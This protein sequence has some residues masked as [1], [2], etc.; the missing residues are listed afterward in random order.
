MKKY[1]GLLLFCIS[2]AAIFSLANSDALA[3]KDSDTPDIVVSR[4]TLSFKLKDADIKSVLA[5]F[6]K[7]LGKNIVAG[8]G[9]SGK[10]TLAF[11]NVKPQEGFE[12]V[13]RSKGYDWYQEGDT[14]VVSNQ[15]T[16][17]TYLLQYANAA[18]VKNALELLMAKGD[19]VS[20]NESYNALIVKTS[21]DNVQRIEKSIRNMDVPPV[22]VMVEARIL[23]FKDTDAG[24]LGVEAN[25]KYQKN[26]ND[27]IA[28]KGFAGK[29][30]DANAAG[31]FAQIITGNIE[32][33]LSSV[34]SKGGYNVIASPR[35][36][37][38]NHKAASILIGSKLGYKTSIISQTSTVQQVNFLEIGTKLTFT[39][40]VS[41]DGFIRM[42]ISPK[43]SD[44]YVQDD[45][46]SENTTETLNEVLVRNG[47]T[48]IIGGLS[49][50]V[51]NQ[52]DMGVPI[53]MHIPFIGAF[54]RK[55]TINNEKRDLLIT[56]TPTIMTPE[57]LQKMQSE[58][59]DFSKK[60]NSWKS[61]LIH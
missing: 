5:I 18:E 12:S 43:I 33:Y 40:H 59:V 58:V 11:T 6:A 32:T 34:L 24:N 37:T 38:I 2:A 31:F 28:T 20:V 30:T 9:V 10:V 39:P 25:V 42:T 49:R 53:L 44:G 13:L 22:Q 29:A 35:I 57:N 19:Q 51:D 48:V 4:G 27:L 16:V 60:Q 54:F 45:L 26:P 36:T 14:I 47:Q 7:Q 61:R 8:D 1:I 15:K 46:P 23:E 55:T 50:S 52:V 56:I 17:R 21:S 41:D 3:A